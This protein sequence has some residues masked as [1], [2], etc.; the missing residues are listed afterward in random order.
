[1]SCRY[2]NIE[3]CFVCCALAH[4]YTKPEK[5]YPQGCLLT[6]NKNRITQQDSCDMTTKA[7]IRYFM[8]DKSLAASYYFKAAIIIFYP[9][10]IDEYEKLAVLL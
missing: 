6:A 2:Y 4:R 1:M 9:N 10:H 5:H 8:R 3:P 7:A